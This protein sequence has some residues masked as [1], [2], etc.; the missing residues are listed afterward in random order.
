MLG[1]LITAAN[2]KIL[3]GAGIASGN[4]VAVLAGIGISLVVGAAIREEAKEYGEISS[5][6]SDSR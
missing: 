6:S 2:A 1:K 5:H 3:I 4:P